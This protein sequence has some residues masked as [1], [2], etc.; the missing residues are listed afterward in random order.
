MCAV[1]VPRACRTST[2]YTK[3]ADFQPL[4][5]RSRS[6]PRALGAKEENLAS[7]SLPLP[8]ADMFFLH[9]HNQTCIV[10]RFQLGKRLK[11]RSATPMP[12]LL[13]PLCLFLPNTLRG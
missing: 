13:A 1:K 6:R 2:L 5:F 3:Q 4:I 9:S 12:F 11:L 7:Q 8:H 10:P